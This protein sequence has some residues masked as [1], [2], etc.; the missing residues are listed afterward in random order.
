MGFIRTIIITARHMKFLAFTQV[1]HCYIWAVNR[2]KAGDVI[3]IPAGVGHKKL[4]ASSDF[5]VVGAYPEGRDWDVLKGEPGERPTADENIAS[6]PI[7][8]SDPLLGIK[9]GLT[10]IWS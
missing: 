9:N 10:R 6:L 3:I 5:A 1:R 2:V 8:K 7:P 4:D